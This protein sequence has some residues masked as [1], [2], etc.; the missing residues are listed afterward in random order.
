MREVEEYASELSEEK[1]AAT[2]RSLCLIIV[3]IGAILIAYFDVAGFLLVNAIGKERIFGHENHTDL[4][5]ILI[6]TGHPAGMLFCSVPFLAAGILLVGGGLSAMGHS[7][8]DVV[9]TFI[10]VLLTYPM[11]I[12][13][14]TTMASN[15]PRAYY[16][17][18]LNAFVCGSLA[19]I[20]FSRTFS[21][22]PAVQWR[23]LASLLSLLAIMGI[24]NS[25]PVMRPYART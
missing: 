12:N 13:S 25:L 9:P 16:P 14:I 8:R 2:V 10:G 23:M 22:A 19:L 24:L 7:R 5:E 11:I 21:R 15:D 17:V 1:E 18:M 4:S 20:F 6:N 3:F